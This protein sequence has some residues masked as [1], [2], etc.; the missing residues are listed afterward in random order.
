MRCGASKSLE[1]EERQ[2]KTQR[3]EFTD[4][5]KESDLSERYVVER[6]YKGVSA[7]FMWFGDINYM[8]EGKGM[9]CEILYNNDHKHIMC[10]SLRCFLH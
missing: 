3:V 5:I 6:S 7:R 1:K 4:Y 2:L 9:S 8:Y 10:Q